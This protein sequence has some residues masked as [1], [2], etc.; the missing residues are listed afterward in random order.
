MSFRTICKFKAAGQLYFHEFQIFHGSIFLGVYRGTETN[1]RVLF[2]G[3][4][5]EEHIDV[6]ILLSEKSNIDSV[7]LS[8]NLDIIQQSLT[9]IESMVCNQNLSCIILKSQLAANT[10]LCISVKTYPT[11]VMPVKV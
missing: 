2:T 7:K 10:D 3:Y 8:A 4:L 11:T 1:K 5:N 6:L 9:T